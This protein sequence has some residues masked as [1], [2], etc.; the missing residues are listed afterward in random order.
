[1]PAGRPSEYNPEL[2]TAICARISQGE[3]LRKILRDPGMPDHVTI[4]KWIRDFPEFLTQ[5]TTA[6]ENQADTLADEITEIADDSSADTITDEDGRERCDKEWV[7]RSRLRVDARKWVASKLKPKKY[8]ER[9]EV[10]GVRMPEPII[11]TVD[12]KTALTLATKESD[13]KGAES[14]KA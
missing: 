1:M 4:Y 10:D 14:A 8:G 12:G 9:L 13:A 6:R 3:S 5:Y 11:L 7:A 2:A